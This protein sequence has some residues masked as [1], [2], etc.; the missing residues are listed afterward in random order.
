MYIMHYVL[1]KK[2]GNFKKRDNND[3]KRN[4]KIL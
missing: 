1:K 2:S 3:K 4:M